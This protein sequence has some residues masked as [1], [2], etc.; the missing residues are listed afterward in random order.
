M[1]GRKNEAEQLN[2]FYRSGRAEMIA[3]YGRRRVGKTFLV[4]AVFQDRITFRHAGLS[5]IEEAGS[6]TLKK[7]LEQFYYSLLSQGMKRSHRPSSWLEAFFMLRQLL[8][9]KDTGARQVVFL[10]ELP[11]M[12][13][14]RSGFLTALEGF[15]NNWGCHRSNLMIIVCGSANS[16]I[17]DKLINNH[18]GLYN[19]VTHVIKLAPFTLKEC[20]E[21]FAAADVNMSRYNITQS[22]MAVG[23]IPYYLGYFERGFSLPQNID[24]L[25]FRRNAPLKDEYDRL[26][27]SIFSRPEDMKKIVRCLQTKNAGYTRNELC[28]LL[29]IS[30]GNALTENLNALIAS[31]FII[32]YVPFGFSKRDVHYKLTD[33]F[34]LFWLRFVGPQTHEETFWQDNQL[35]PSITEWKGFAFEQVCFNHIEQIKSALGIAGVR[36]THSAWIKRSDDTDGAQIDLLIERGDNVLNSCEIKFSE[37]EFKVDKSY[38]RTL[39]NRQ[40]ILMKTISPRIVIHNTLITT[41]G[42]AYNEYSGF[43]SKTITMDQLFT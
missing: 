25:F 36:T 11:W 22:Y 43:F 14:P 13:T 20:E 24:N 28:S 21:Y 40:A 32:R 29:G 12:D 23:G 26:F 39:Q 10:D 16:W 37:S 8:E 31:D 7:Q 5:P 35:S 38:Y 6:A 18:S 34:C 27:S 17:L 42:L 2:R 3:I 19:R 15:W 1:I 4:D 9:A 33:P 30:S 41:Y